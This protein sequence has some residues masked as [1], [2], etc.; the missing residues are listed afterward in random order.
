VD[1]QSTAELVATFS[2]TELYLASKEHSPQYDGIVM[3]FAARIVMRK[4]HLSAKELTDAVGI[5]KTSVYRW[6]RADPIKYRSR[7]QWGLRALAVVLIEG[8]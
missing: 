4:A 6:L 2:G 3:C 7:L 5:G 1:E 8:E